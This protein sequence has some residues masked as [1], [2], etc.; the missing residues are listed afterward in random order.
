MRFL[1]MQLG[2][3]L[4]ALVLFNLPAFAQA[5][6]GNVTGNVLDPTGATVPGA[7]IIARNN[8]TGV[9]NTTTSTSAGGYRFE[10]LPIGTYTISVTAPGFT[11]TEV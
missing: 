8:A 5:T 1:R 2:A 6:S 3:V 10:N 9:E 7:T 11:K 4:A